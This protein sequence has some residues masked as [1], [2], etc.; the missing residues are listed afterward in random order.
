MRKVIWGA[1]GGTAKISVDLVLPAMQRSELC[2]VRAIA[3]RSL[4]KAQTAAGKLGVPVAY[5][6][7]EELLADPEIEAIYNPLPNH[8]H[9]DWTIKALEAGKHVLCE[10]PIALNAQDATRLRDA[11]ERTGLLLAEAFMVRHHP[12]WRMAREI[13]QS[14]RIGDVLAMQEIFAIQMLD[15][16]NIRNIKDVGGGGLYDLGCYAVT[17]SRF[18]FGSDPVTV[19]GSFDFDPDFETDRLMSGIAEYEGGRQLSFICATQMVPR[20][21]V[22]ILGSKGRIEIQIPFNA[23]SDEE[24]EIYVDD[25][26]DLRGGG[27]EKIVLPASNQYGLQGDA[28]SR[29]VLGE[30]SLEWDVEDAIVNMKVIDAFFRSSKN[31]SWEKL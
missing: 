9:V 27:I 16:N 12:Q 30:K 25:G 4:E 22:H 8:M 14:G 24:M 18:I 3:S 13:A 29:A 26:R 28:F 20:Q 31:K 2:E 15:P 17:T 19:T 10:K 11:V 21:R 6:S 5:G 7:Y 1:I 23:I